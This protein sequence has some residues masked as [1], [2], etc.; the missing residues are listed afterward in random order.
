MPFSSAAVTWRTHV[1]TWTRFFLG[2]RLGPYHEMDKPIVQ[3]LLKL[4]AVR[5]DDHFY[6]IGC[7]DARLLLAASR[8][9]FHAKRCTGLELD[10][11]VA[12]VARANVSAAGLDSSVRVLETDARK[13]D[14]SEATVISLYLSERG[15]AQLLPVLNPA[16]L[17]RPST[18][19]VSFLFPVPSWTPVRTELT[20]GSNIPMYLFTGESL[21]QQLRDQHAR[22]QEEE[23][24][25]NKAESEKTTKE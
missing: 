25:R 15:N 10:A 6:D 16:L 23:T 13:A 20:E 12:A 3:S 19:V 2:N 22:D 9:P 18:R 1:S 4:G 7:G 8:A 11:K 24:R 5:S 17:A 14:L 21:P